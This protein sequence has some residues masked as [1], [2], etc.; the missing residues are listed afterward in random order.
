M[1]GIV[2]DEYSTK[3]RLDVTVRLT[4]EQQLLSGGSSWQQWQEEFGSREEAERWKA[5][6]IAE[7][8]RL[9]QSHNISGPAPHWPD[10]FE[11]DSWEEF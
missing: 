3:W 6:K 10:E 1:K 2:M 4:P 5:E 7:C 9:G 8:T 11:I